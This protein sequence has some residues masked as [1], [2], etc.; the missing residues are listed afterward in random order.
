MV[1][2]FIMNR[3]LLSAV[4]MGVIAPPASCQPAAPPRL[5]VM[6]TVDQLIPD[7]LERF[8]PQLSGGLARITRTG[9]YFPNGLQDHASTETAPGHSTIL[10]GRSPA[11]TGITANDL[12]VSDPGSPLVDASGPGASPARFRGTTL[13]DW[14]LAADPELQ[15]LSISRKDRGAILPIGRMAAPVLWYAPASGIF[16]TSRWYTPV[17]PEWVVAWN[18]RGGVARMGD[19]IWNLLRPASD[20]PEPDFQEW[21]R[22]GRGN[23]FPYQ[24]PSDSTPLWA[25]IT[26]MP[27][28]DSLTMDLALEGVR[29]M[30]MGQRSRPDLLSVSLST[31]DAVGHA[32]G[33]QSREIHDQVLRLDH[34]LG[35]FLDS[36]ETT[37]GRG[38]LLVALTSDHGIQPYPEGVV[39]S[40]RPAGRVSL[41]PVLRGIDSTLSLRYRTDF[42]LD[43]DIGLLFGNLTEMRVRG[44]NVDS[45]SAAAAVQLATLPGV[46]RTFTPATLAAAAADD[47]EA[48]LWRRRI[49][50]DFEWIAAAALYPNYMWTVGTTSTGHGTSNLADRN[51]PIAFMGSG[52]PAEVSRRAVRTVDIAP[53]LAAILGIR[54]LQVVEGVALPEVVGP[55][56]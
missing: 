39:A 23:T 55:P 13:A 31:T 48:G 33:P 1:V 51:V 44:V 37:V 38:R 5:V 7:Y 36:L 10:S 32:W 11:S 45:V 46:R 47:E 15:V 14:M 42:R 28:M 27:W 43:S 4:A 50:T 8:A 20:Y 2:L 30:R 3:I 6:I 17:L 49:P 19:R 12:G 54:P 21:E 52:V 40:G 41:G 35:W 53:T 56:R 18:A 16:T 29:V 24:L 25:G 34:W 22:A 9:T 26:Q